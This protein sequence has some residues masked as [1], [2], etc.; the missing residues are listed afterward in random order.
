MKGG[1][2]IKLNEKKNDYVE[3]KDEGNK[4]HIKRKHG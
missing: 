4:R 3:N 2:K 1:W